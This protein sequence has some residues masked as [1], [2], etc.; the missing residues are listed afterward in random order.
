[1]KDKIKRYLPY[2]G[3]V[4]AI[5]L[6]WFF[7]SGYLFF[8]DFSLGP[9]FNISNWWSGVFYQDLIMKGLSLVLPVDFLQKVFIGLIILLLL[10]AG[11][12]IVEQFTA[13]KWLIFVISL[14]VVFNPFVYDRF[15]YGQ[16]GV[17]LGL[18]FFVLFVGNMLQYILAVDDSD[19]TKRFKIDWTLIRASIF[20]SLTI[21][22]SLHFI[23]FIL[24]LVI[25]FLVILTADKRLF[26]QIFI[27][28]FI[29]CAIVVVAINANVIIGIVGNFSNTANFV[30]SGIIQNDLVAFQTSGK[31]GGEAI[32]N[33]LMMSGFWGKDQHRYTDLTSFDTNWGRSFLLLLPLILYGVY[34]G[35]KSEDKKIKWLTGGLLII[36]G[37]ATFLAVGVR[38]GLTKAVTLWL[39][40]NLP[41][42]RGLR[43]TQKWV[44]IEVVVYL[45]F[46]SWGA[47][48]FFQKKIIA[49]QQSVFK[50]FLAAIIIM[51]TPLLLWG[52][53]GQV[54]PTNYPA[55]WYEADKLI[56]AESHCQ[57]NILFLPWHAYM[58]FTW[59]GN[60]VSNPA[61]SFFTCSVISGTNM[62]WGGIYDNSQD[63]TGKKVDNWLSASGRTDLLS[64]DNLS[65]KYV[66]LAK[67]VDWK[68]YQWLSQESQLKLIS[69]TATLRI[70]KV[71]E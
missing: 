10:L 33:V 48:E 19:K 70:Y 12:K 69:D 32:S 25:V 63:P 31:T 39:F 52:F 1:M 62:E 2:A 5:I 44:A 42:Y 24:A 51:Q 29:I 14:F 13:D 27:L 61:P 36:F 4:L 20:A 28:N 53:G 71:N 15:L 37:I 46:L 60:I 65:I 8:S 59:I 47:K 64:D 43:E 41:F 56:T 67:E 58:G 17:I 50:I 66:I 55:D 23:F 30:Q 26:S 16:F 11:K 35:F 3:V 6:P 45:I 57:G 68:N 40:D 34:R 49:R 9:N 38:T 7:H 22:H 54:R 18:G 21:L